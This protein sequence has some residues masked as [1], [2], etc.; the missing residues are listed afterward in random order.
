MAAKQLWV[1]VAGLS[2]LLAAC[3]SSDGVGPPLPPCTSGTSL[4]L[5][6]GAYQSIDPGPVSGCVVFPASAS[7]TEYLLVPQAA[8]GTPNDTQSFKLLG[9]A[10][11]PSAVAS[12][13]AAEAG[14]GTASPAE[15][16]HL[17]LRQAERSR[18]YPVP[19]QPQ[20][21]T[22]LQPAVQATTQASPPPRRPFT[23]ADSGMINSFKVCGDLS[24]K[25]LP[26]VDAALMKIGQHI[27]IYVDTAAPTPGLTQTDLDALR[28][29]F[30]T[31]L[32][33]IDTTA[34]GRESDIDNNRVV[35]V[36]MTNRVNQLVTAT[37]C[38]TSGFVAGFSF[39]ADIDPTFASG[40][41]NG[42][43]FYS[44]VP[45]SNSTLSCQHTVRGVKRLVPVTFIHEFQHMISYNH[46]VLE[47]RGEAEI[48]WLN[49]SLSHY[50]EELG[51]RSFLPADTASYCFY[52]FGDLYNAAQYFQAPQ[53]N[54]LIDTSGIGGLAN[55]GAYWL[56]LRYLIDQYSA[57]TSFAQRSV[58]TRKLDITSLTGPPNVA[59]Q[60]GQSFALLL[61]RWALANWASDLPGFTA[62]PELQYKMWRFR[63]DYGWLKNACAA[64]G[65][66]TTALPTTLPLVP[67]MGAGSSVNLTGVLRAGSG[68]Y[69][70]AQQPAGAARFGLLFSNG[71]GV[72]LR[73]S[74]VPR[75]NVI[76]IQ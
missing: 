66:N 71:A 20:R 8:T 69:F 37:Q 28:A 4:A 21:P 34:F 63:S 7:A 17:F 48:L 14:P 3:K 25:T 18:V 46:H 36:L 72:A 9:S 12:L 55:R 2:W 27:A 41:N 38:T 49:E 61:E 39:G 11:A 52:V 73:G 42:E 16:F 15:Q 56:F 53:N 58:F 45:D 44:I 19:P 35:I 51:G 67:G 43:I 24:C 76:R 70:R 40:Y 75:L 57:D 62:P 74:L 60:T 29:V 64:A 6:I 50:A 33:E 31:Q 22:G 32:Y 5:A 65:V 30:D 47:R 68:A 54:F 10:L 13:V 26:T 1:G 23:P 59:T